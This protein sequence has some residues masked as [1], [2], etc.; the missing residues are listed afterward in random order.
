MQEVFSKIEDLKLKVSILLD[1]KKKLLQE[2]K[3]LVE[4]IKSLEQEMEISKGKFQQKE[5]E[6]KL[7]NVG[8]DKIREE[9]TKYIND[10]DELIKILS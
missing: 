4:K 10:I 2:N 8:E 9:L 7:K 6:K 3:L 5:I 1:E